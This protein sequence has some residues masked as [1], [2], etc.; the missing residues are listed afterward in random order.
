MGNYKKSLA[1]FGAA[2][3]FIAGALFL[4]WRESAQVNLKSGIRL[5]ELNSPHASE[6]LR[7]GVNKDP[8]NYRLHYILAKSLHKT[9]FALLK[10]KRDAKKPLFEARRSLINALD[11]RF[12]SFDHLLLGFNYELTGQPYRALAH[13]NISFFFS[14]DAGEP[15]SWERLRPDQAGA[16]EEY[17]K[18]GVTGVALIMAYNA[19]AGYEV[20]P[21]FSSAE[22]LLNDFF[23]AEPPDKWLSKEWE[24]GKR[25]L[26][27]LYKKR[28]DT[29]REGIVSLLEEAGFV[30]LARFLDSPV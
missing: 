14:Q 9:A 12:D 27:E 10:E 25:K 2:V 23:L 7:N 15:D 18:A 13:Y 30:F 17:F 20:R 24:E 22:V 19:L 16:A 5:Y 3:F 4:A 29:E 11:L 21:A 1:L 28:A 26:K 8:Y 6:I